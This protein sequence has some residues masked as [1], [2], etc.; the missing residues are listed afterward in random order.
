MRIE[1]SELEELQQNLVRSHA[2]GMGDEVP[3][4][5]VRLMLL[6]KVHGLSQ[7]YSGV[8]KEIVQ[9]LVDFYS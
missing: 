1:D 4:D 6:L 2:C 7:G 5:I 8:R 9:R 3:E